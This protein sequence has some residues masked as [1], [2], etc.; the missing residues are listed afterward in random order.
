MAFKERQ[1]LDSDMTIALGGINK[2]TN[3]PNPTKIE[4][5]FL[6]TKVVESKMS[7]DGTAKLHILQ[8]STGNVG[9]W[10]KTDM[11]RRLAGLQPGAMIRISYTGK[12]KIPGKNDMYKYKVEVDDE[13]TIQVDSTENT[14]LSAD[15][16]F[17]DD[18]PELPYDSVEESYEDAGDEDEVLDEAPYRAPT[19]PKKAA[20]TPDAARQA[21]VKE[22]L[23][24]SKRA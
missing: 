22:L 10:G 24:K 1:S 20:A 17:E 18:V 23:A 2:K 15:E 7:R 5:Y 21:K 13:N 12:Q 11:D 19:P 6:G 3:K 9:V 16:V 4:G 14:L 8:T